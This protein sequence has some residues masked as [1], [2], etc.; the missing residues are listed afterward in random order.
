MVTLSL[1]RQHATWNI[2]LDCWFKWC[3]AYIWMK[4]N[5]LCV[6]VWAETVHPGPFV[7][8]MEAIS[9]ET[10]SRHWS[11]VCV[12]AKAWLS[13]LH[14]NMLMYLR[15][16]LIGPS[17]AHP[18]PPVFTGSLQSVLQ[19]DPCHWE[20]ACSANIM[21]TN[22]SLLFGTSRSNPATVEEREN[23]SKRK[24]RMG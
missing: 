19:S 20:W 23:K 15:C 8:H 13:P 5:D 17:D 22:T 16:A 21:Q 10:L 2:L 14:S 12:L 3:L 9:L 18:A 11:C 6:K 24:G 1:L 7:I 4:M